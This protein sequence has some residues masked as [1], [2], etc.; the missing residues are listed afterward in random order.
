VLQALELMTRHTTQLVW[1][2]SA[3]LR[4]KVLTLMGQGT[5]KTGDTQWIGHI[6]KRLHL[7]DESRRKRQSDGVLYAVSP[8]DVMDMMARYHVAQIQ[9]ND[10]KNPT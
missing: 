2:K 4:D 3:L 1:V 6:L 7:I 10:T 5:E 8:G 9:L